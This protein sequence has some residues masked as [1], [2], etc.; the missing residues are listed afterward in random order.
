MVFGFRAF[1]LCLSLVKVWN[2]DK[3]E[4]NRIANLR[5]RKKS[6]S[7]GPSILLRWTGRQPFGWLRVTLR[8][9]WFDKLTMT[10]KGQK[11]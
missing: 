7:T 6:P 4:V 10:G 3:A 5:H 8:V 2:L 11:K 9:K 1:V